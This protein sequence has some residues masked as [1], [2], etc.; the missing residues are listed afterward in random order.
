MLAVGLSMA[1][2]LA[3]AA[4]ILVVGHTGAPTGS[5]VQPAGSI[6]GREQLLDILA[7]LRRPQTRADLHNPVVPRLL[8]RYG[9]TQ[10]P[11]D[12]LGQP[13]VS[14]I[15]RAQVTPWGESIYLV[16]L[17]PLTRAQLNATPQ[18]RRNLARRQE[19]IFTLTTNTGGCCD[20]AASIEAGGSGSWQGVSSRPGHPIVTRYLWLVPDGVAKVKLVLP[21]QAAPNTYG[22]PI[23]PRV[24]TITAVPHG[25]VV[26]VQ[27]DR[28]DVGGP[29]L[30]ICYAADGRAIKRIGNF[31]TL[32]RVV[33]P[34]HP[35][36]ATAQS[37]A[38]EHNPSTPNHVWVSPAIGSPHT[39]FMIHFKVLITGA[40]YRYRLTGP[41]CPAIQ[42]N[43][44]SGGGDIDLR[45]DIWRDSVRANTGTWCPGTY[46]VSAAIAGVGRP[47][48]P[49]KP[50]PQSF[51]SAAFSVR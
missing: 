14:L 6:P 33:P 17:R 38:A 36:P 45:G 43:F 20:T 30:I 5:T 26:A 11:F 51:G 28:P 49:S 42:P 34:P 2:A 9:Q 3:V 35:A 44:A 4:V 7:V 27:V 41:H 15:R 1:V 16:P 25:N 29:P 23:Y 37:R 19:S 21:R 46:R 24:K 13:D 31:R 50:G 22:A 32:S 40:F 47:S 18:L 48:I 10:G 12:R 8:S 39:R